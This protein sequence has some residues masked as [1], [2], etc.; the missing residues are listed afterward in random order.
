MRVQMETRKITIE[1]RRILFGF[2]LA[3]GFNI[4]PRI[5]PIPVRSYLRE[6]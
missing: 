3:F 4:S 6:P 2:V 5:P 1:K